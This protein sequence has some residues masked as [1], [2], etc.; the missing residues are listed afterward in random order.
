MAN[1]FSGDASCKALWRFESGALATDTIGVNTLNLINS[2]AADTSKYKEGAAS[3]ALVAAS[4]QY[5]YIHDAALVTSGFPL[6]STDSVKKITVCCWLYA[7]SNGSY[8]RVW[9]KND[10]VGNKKCLDVEINSGA[11][12]ITWGNGGSTAT[13]INPLLTIST[14]VWYHL[15]IMLDGVNTVFRLYL[16]NASTGATSYYITTPG[17]AL[18]V[19]T[20]DWQVGNSGIYGTDNDGNYWDGDIDEL[21]VFNRLLI[22]EEVGAIIN[23]AYTG[24]YSIPSPGN[25][26]TYNANIQ[27]RWRFETGALT[28]DS[29]PAAGGNGANTLSLAGTANPVSDPFGVLEGADAAYLATAGSYFQ[30]TD[31]N[32]STNFP[33]KSTD[34]VKEI[35]I[36]GW[37]IPI[38]WAPDSSHPR[39]IWGKVSTLTNGIGAYLDNNGHL[40]V[41][42]SGSTNYDTGFILSLLNTY[43]VAFV[44]DANAQTLVVRVFN[45]AT[46]SVSDYS[47]SIASVPLGAGIF[48]LGFGDIGS[49][50]YTT[51]GFL[52]EWVA[53]NALLSDSDIDLIRGQT[54][55]PVTRNLH[56]T[57]AVVSTTSSPMLAVL[58][59]LATSPAVVST[60]SSPMLAILRKLASSPAVTTSTSSP[61]L[62]ILRKLACSPAVQSSTPDSVMLAVLRKLV[63]S[64][65]VVSSVSTPNLAVQRALAEIAA[66]ISETSDTVYLDLQATRNLATDVAVLSSTSAINLAVLRKLATACGVTTSTPNIMLA[67]L[68]ELVS[69]VDCQ[70]ETPAINLAVLRKLITTVAAQSQT[71]AVGLQILRAL[72]TA[73]S[74]GTVSPGVML[75]ILRK[76]V[77]D[78]PVLSTTSSAEIG[79]LLRLATAVA[80]F[81]TTPDDVIL[82]I[83]TGAGP[84]A[85]PSLISLAGAWVGGEANALLSAAEAWLKSEETKA[86]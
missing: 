35:T 43:H 19:C 8:R 41:S 1:N 4:D 13:T 48:Y 57:P 66:V 36:C 46:G 28:T 79:F 50:Y 24:A 76:L 54:Y 27:G 68:R 73:V 44:I 58:R 70:T 38:A 53:A 23:G 21:V 49:N 82:T 22:M 10:Y 32:L 14:G 17:S 7:A 80:V 15:T 75:A 67:V 74:V 64:P 86:D 84:T 31:A 77:T 37:I 83:I 62:N 59:K 25:V 71:S 11:L 9:A 16:Y 85:P 6:N 20:A 65:A 39:W 2:P 18:G 51:V 69:T 47:T 29:S 56:T 81:T 42:I 72:Q 52:D 5:G 45:K 63:T 60:V 33:F 3:L 26:F 55:G 30:I 78:I 12:L 34:S 61:L 40:I